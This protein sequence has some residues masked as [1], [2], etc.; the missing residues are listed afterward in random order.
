MSTACVSGRLNTNSGGYNEKGVYIIVGGLEAKK[1]VTSAAVSAPERTV[2]VTGYAPEPKSTS[3]TSPL[4][5]S[6]ALTSYSKGFTRYSGTPFSRGDP[7][8]L[9]TCPV[10]GEPEAF[11]DPA[12]PA[13]AGR[14]KRMLP[15][16]MSTA[17]QVR[18]GQLYSTAWAVL[19]SMY[20]ATA[21]KGSH[22]LDD[23]GGKVTGKVGLHAAVL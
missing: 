12:A 9:D 19:T 20:Y 8:F 23:L 6:N 10:W 3:W 15:M 1:A 16:W 14:R 17:D 18:L 2:G 22:S 4:S 7:S 13:Y 11:K 5:R 21:V